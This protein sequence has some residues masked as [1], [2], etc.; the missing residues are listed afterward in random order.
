M[1]PITTLISLIVINLV[2]YFLLGLAT[3]RVFHDRPEEFWLTLAVGVLG[4]VVGWLLGFLASPSTATE[5]ERFSA[6]SGAIATFVSGYF[7]SKFDP[8]LT[9]LLENPDRLATPVV[10]LKLVVFVACLVSGALIMY[11][12]RSY[13]KGTITLTHHSTARA[14]L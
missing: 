14:E 13:L 4:V 3:W 1:T 10:G 2:S 5:N 8:V 6:Y 12:V 7:V 11:M 9:K